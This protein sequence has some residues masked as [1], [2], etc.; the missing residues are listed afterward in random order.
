MASRNK[1]N[2]AM[3]S[4]N[5]KLKVDLI[6][7]FFRK[8][9]KA[10]DF[11]RCGFNVFISHRV[12]VFNPENISLANNVYFG[13]G[14]TLFGHGGIDI[15]DAVVFGDDIKIM[16]SNHSYDTLAPATIPFTSDNVCREV[17][18]NKGAWIG[19]NS[20]ILPGVSIGE[21]SVVGA[22][23]VVTKSTEPYG[24]YAGNPARLIK[25]RENKDLSKVK[26]TWVEDKN[27]K[28]IFFIS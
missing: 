17:T 26:K 18:I 21:F 28:S 23:S 12:K 3:I 22:G 4:K 14:C 16:S 20:I 24:I 25:Y 15:G 8:R 5:L 6:K 13:P 9:V 1:S 2:M 10:E 7:L 19:S 27:K 11:K